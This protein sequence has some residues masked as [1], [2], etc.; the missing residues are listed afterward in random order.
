M[1]SI[2]SL[3][4]HVVERPL[5]EICIVVSQNVF[6]FWLWCL[7]SSGCVVCNHLFSL[8]NPKRTYPVPGKRSFQLNTI[9]LLEQICSSVFNAVLDT[10]W[11]CPSKGKLLRPRH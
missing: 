5:L 10:I 11:T 6:H 4:T 1:A 7:I 3:L 8:S 9:Q 2:S